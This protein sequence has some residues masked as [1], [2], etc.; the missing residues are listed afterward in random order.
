MAEQDRPD[1]G[2]ILG[3]VIVIV[4][5]IV[6]VTL[7]VFEYIKYE[8]RAEVTEKTVKS[9]SSALRSLRATEQER[10]SSYQWVDE[11]AGI[12]RIPVERA[13]ELTLRDW[14]KRPTRSKPKAEEPAPAPEGA[15]GAPGGS[16]AEPGAAEDKK[17]P[18]PGQAPQE[19]PAKGPAG[20]QKP[21]GAQPQA[22]APAGKP[23]Q[24]GAP[25][26]P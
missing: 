4:V 25:G 16:P 20:V 26:K 5:A 3:N 17:G 14:P 12:V 8:L 19:G 15:E 10:L 18:A 11:K 2:A 9:E 1:N 23:G 21:E 6:A 24:D 22:P 7:G 13:I